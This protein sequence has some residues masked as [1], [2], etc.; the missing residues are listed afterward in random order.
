[1]EF[2]F[3]L[4]KKGS[5]SGKLYEGSFTYK[6]LTIG[7]QGRAGVLKAKLNGDLTAID[8]EIDRLHEMLSWLRY[9]LIDYPDWW[10]ECSFGENLYDLNILEELYLR[11]VDFEK[12][13]TKKIDVQ[14]NKKDSDT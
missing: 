4:N 5:S 13:W 10:R 3:E 14:S 9:G 11:V 6:R 12:E 7:S 1:M 2:T 8:P